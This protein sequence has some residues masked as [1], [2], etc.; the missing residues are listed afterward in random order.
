M[1]H[2]ALIAGLFVLAAPSLAQDVEI[3]KTDED[4]HFYRLNYASQLA[5]LNERLIEA[6]E[7]ILETTER[8]AVIIVQGDHGPPSEYSMMGAARTNVWERHSILNAIY[9]P[10]GGAEIFPED[11]T[12]VNTFRILFNEY[13]G[14]GLEVLEDACYFSLHTEQFKFTDVT[15]RVT[16]GE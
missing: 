12:P 7:G 4:L 14:T 3:I 6:I 11:L 16:R 10:G 13:F 2:I 5:E 8:E 15:E 1:K 9:L